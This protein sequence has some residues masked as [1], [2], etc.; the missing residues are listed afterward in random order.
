M[1]KRILFILLTIALTA[2]KVQAQ[3]FRSELVD[4][5][6]KSSTLKGTSPSQAKAFLL[7]FVLPGA[8]EYYAGSKTMATV[9]ASTEL[10]LWTTFASF[11]IYGNWKRNDYHLY[12]V[13][14]AGVELSGK[15]DQYFVDIEDY[16]SLVAFNDAKL[17]QRNLGAVYPETEYWDWNWDN[18]T[19]RE[20]YEKMR[21]SSDQAF[22]RSMI[23]VAAI[24]L[25]HITSGI[26]AVR[27]AR[28]AGKPDENR[29]R[30]GFFGLPEGGMVV[31]LSKS[32]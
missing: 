17:Q 16:M 25:N 15:N 31:A 11:R 24:V 14:H 6:E 5:Q 23:V 10:A 27:L 12:A 7:S 4:Q 13:A 3:G 30:I 28:K 8:G 19:S 21:I 20:A 18:E 32:W 29:T 9:F 2:Q 1:T 26:D 22:N